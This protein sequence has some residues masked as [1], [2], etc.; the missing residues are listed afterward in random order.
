M[1]RIYSL[2]IL[3]SLTL[4]LASCDGEQM[5]Q[6]ELD[7]FIGVIERYDIAETNGYNYHS[8]QEVDDWIT[9]ADYIEQRIDSSEELKIYLEHRS[10]Q[11]NHFDE[12]DTQTESLMVY[13]YFN[14]RI[15]TQ[16]DDGKIE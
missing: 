11:L 14:S 8:V 16:I 9:N 5:N 7:I 12:H 2:F 1:K 13:Y 6:D 10:V 3:I 4:F 15:G